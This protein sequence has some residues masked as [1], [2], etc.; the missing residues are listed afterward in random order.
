M[1]EYLCVYFSNNVFQRA[2]GDCLKRIISLAGG[3]KEEPSVR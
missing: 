2:L 1:G 3:K